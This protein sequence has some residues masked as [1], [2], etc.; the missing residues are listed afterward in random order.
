MRNPMSHDRGQSRFW[1]TETG[2]AHRRGR[3]RGPIE[4][5]GSEGSRSRPNR[6]CPIEDWE[7]TIRALEIAVVWTEVRR[8]RAPGCGLA[9]AVD[10]EQ[11][12]AAVAAFGEWV[13]V[14]AAA[15][16]ADAR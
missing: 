6:G 14:L 3:S 9:D 11:S 7:R 10:A 2:P 1:Q 5:S 12:G 16:A 15:D 8:H 4:G 13:A